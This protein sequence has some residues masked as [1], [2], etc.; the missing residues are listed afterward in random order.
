[1]T[2]RADGEAQEPRAGAQLYEA[3]TS[4]RQPG[5]PQVIAVECLSVCRRPCTIS[6]SAPGAWTYV[7]GDFAY[8]TDPEDIL[9]AARLYADSPQGLIPWKQRPQAFKKGVVARIPP[10]NPEQP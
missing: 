10:L 4:A 3:L 9:A 2:C 6:F 1:V 8:D 5:D 7:Y